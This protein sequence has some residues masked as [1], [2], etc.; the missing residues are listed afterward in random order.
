MKRVQFCGSIGGSV[1]VRDGETPEQALARAE[2]TLLELLERGAKRLSDDGR[3]PNICL[4]LADD[5]A[6]YDFNSGHSE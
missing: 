4:E 1:V 3:G 5:G 6:E 2:A